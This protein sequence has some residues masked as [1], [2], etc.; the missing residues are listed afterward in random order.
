MQLCVSV[1]VFL[2]RSLA[3]TLEYGCHPCDSIVVEVSDSHLGG[4]PCRGSFCHYGT[5]CHLLTK[6]VKFDA[7]PARFVTL[8]RFVTTW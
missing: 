4:T 7:Q 8:A 1:S 3:V 6:R 2:A 5:F